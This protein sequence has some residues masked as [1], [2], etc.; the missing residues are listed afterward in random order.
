MRGYTHIINNAG[1]RRNLAATLEDLLGGCWDTFEHSYR[2]GEAA[3]GAMSKQQFADYVMCWNL[4]EAEAKRL[5]EEIAG[6]DAE[7]IARE[8]YLMAAWDFY[9]SMDPSK[10]GTGD[11]FFG[12][13]SVKKSSLS[14]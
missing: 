14:F 3:T 7:T 11:N 9:F 10:R 12:Q 8:Q 2:G 6:A 13:L 5:F 4:S 1:A